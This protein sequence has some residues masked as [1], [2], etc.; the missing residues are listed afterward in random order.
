MSS[1]GS[2]IGPTKIT[3]NLSSLHVMQGSYIMNV[4]MPRTSLSEG[5][6]DLLSLL[7]PQIVSWRRHE[8]LSCVTT[9]VGTYNMD[10]S[11]F[12]SARNYLP[13]APPFHGAWFNETKICMTTDLHP[14][15]KENDSGGEVR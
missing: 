3:Q 12:G 9:F 14:L 4:L 13:V 2:T 11:A 10:P 5:S 1:L 7:Q 6:L 8:I 15:K